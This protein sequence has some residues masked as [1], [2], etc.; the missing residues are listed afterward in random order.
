MST[1]FNPC[2]RQHFEL[3]KK[4]K[5]DALEACMD[6]MSLKSTRPRMRNDKHQWRSGREIMMAPSTFLSKTFDFLRRVVRF[7]AAFGWLILLT[8]SPSVGNL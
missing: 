3:K 7:L 5:K 1:A 4:A 6:F 8:L 2:R